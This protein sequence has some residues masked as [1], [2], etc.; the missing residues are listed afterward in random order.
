MSNFKNAQK[1]FGNKIA[2]WISLNDIGRRFNFSKQYVAAKKHAIIKDYLRSKYAKIIQNIKSQ[3]QVIDTKIEDTSPIWICWWD[4]EEQMPAL[5]R[6]CYQSVC[7]YANKQPV[8]LITK[9]NYQEYVTIP[10]E[11]TEKVKSKLITL[12]HFSD[13]LRMCLLY[14]NGGIWLDA[15]IYLTQDMPSYAQK[16]FTTIKHPPSGTFVS[17]C[18]WSGFCIGGGKHH[19]LFTFMRAMLFDY[20]KKETSLIDYYLIDYLISLA[21][22]QLPSVNQSIQGVPHN[23]IQLYALQQNLN[24]AFDNTLLDEY[25]SD[26]FIHKLRWK[27]QLSTK[28]EDGKPTFYGHILSRYTDQN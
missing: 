12:T 23:N 7:K 22:E 26:T 3:Q 6:A 11:I 28:T 13:I 27:G 18:L 21:Y 2:F 1:D 9:Y 19:P 17:N 16:N 15:T 20:W 10:A 14:E 4:G 24:N 25:T 5:T 8:I